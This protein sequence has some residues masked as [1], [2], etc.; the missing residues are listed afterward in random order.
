MDLT[1]HQQVFMVFFAIFW[2]TVASVQGRWKAFQLPLVFRVPRVGARVILSMGIL[3]LLPLLFFAY[4]FWILAGKTPT[5]LTVLDFVEMVVNG[6]LP[7]FAVFGFYRLWLGIVERFPDIFYNKERKAFQNKN[8]HSDPINCTSH[9]PEQE[10][11]VVYLGSDLGRLNMAWALGYIL[12]AAVAPW[13]P[14]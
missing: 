2:G 9:N 4:V 8:W 14:L 11:P 13:I 10:E 7:A 6:V 5:G 3:N 1:S 12:V